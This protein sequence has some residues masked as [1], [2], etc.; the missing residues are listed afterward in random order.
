MSLRRVRPADIQPGDEVEHRVQRGGLTTIRRGVVENLN[1]GMLNMVGG[2]MVDPSEA[3][4]WFV[5]VADVKDVVLLTEAL[6]E[7]SEVTE[8]L[9][10]SRTSEAARDACRRRLEVLAGQVRETISSMTDPSVRR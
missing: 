4:E 6:A 8:K 1:A 2:G 9:D 7:V 5:R 3:G 10:S